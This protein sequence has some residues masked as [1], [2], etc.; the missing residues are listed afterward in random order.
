MSCFFTLQPSTFP[1]PLYLYIYFLN[2]IKG[3]FSLRLEAK[4]LLGSTASDVQLTFDFCDE[5]LCILV[6]YCCCRFYYQE[7]HS[8]I[9]NIV[10][11]LAEM[12]AKF[13][14]II[15]D[16]S[17]EVILNYIINTGYVF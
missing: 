8:S 12:F 15:H 13:P 14:Q 11:R 2:A 3:A 6:C 9:P 7:D 4:G 10:Q 1:R 17:S 5:A 16:F